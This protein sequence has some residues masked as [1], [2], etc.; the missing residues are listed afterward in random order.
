M[1]REHLDIW[2]I[3]CIYDAAERKPTGCFTN[4]VSDYV[5]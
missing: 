3:F 5:S 4:Y 1:Q 2:E